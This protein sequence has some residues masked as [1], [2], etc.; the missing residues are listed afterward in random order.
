[1]KAV[2][3]GVAVLLGLVLFL[4]SAIGASATAGGDAVPSAPV[5]ANASPFIGGLAGCTVPDPTAT[6]G[7]VTRAMA[8]VL[9][10]I[11][12]HFGSLPTACWDRHAWNPTS[13]HPRGKACDI[14]FGRIG[15]FPGTADVTSGWALATW[16]RANAAA[17]R[18]NYVIWQGR[19]W[20]RSHDRD[21]WRAYAGGGVYNPSDPTGGHYDH[22]HVST[23]E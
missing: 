14:T 3:A 23:T 2:G 7:C 17:L 18:A 13:D 15:T 19:I 1:M 11:E 12:A 21:G 6:G 8:W 16:L 20:S 10:Q 9:S 5:A 4:G 22:V